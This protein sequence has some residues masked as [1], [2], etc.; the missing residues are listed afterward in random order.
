[1]EM[2]QPEPAISWSVLT[3]EHTERSA[4]W[5][6][7]LGV[8]AVAGAIAAVFFSNIL[9]ACILIIGAG[10]IGF[11]AA[12]G[13]REH[14]VRIDERGISVDGTLYPYGSIHS[15][16]IAEE[17]HKPELI[18]TVKSFLTPRILLSLEGTSPETIRSRLEQYIEETEA[19]A[20]L[21]DSLAEI[22][23]L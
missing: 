16:S 13:P 20:R 23:G 12:R 5:Y 15:F 2:T 21:S 18:L 6:W 3:H 9:L 8:L 22:F 19:E 14:M 7:T 4:D 17:P 1:M 10:S 11:L